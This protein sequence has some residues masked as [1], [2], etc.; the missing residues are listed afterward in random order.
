MNFIGSSILLISACV[1]L[2]YGVAIFADALTESKQALA[3][4]AAC[5][6]ATA[7]LCVAL[8]QLSLLFILVG[9]TAISLFVYSLSRENLSISRRFYTSG[10]VSATIGALLTLMG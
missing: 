1:V 4:I 2:V 3:W 5:T 10:C 7:L 8:P 6:M 9:P